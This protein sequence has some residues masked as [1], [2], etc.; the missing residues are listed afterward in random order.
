MSRFPKA[1][2]PPGILTVSC[3]LWDSNDFLYML[4]IN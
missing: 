4:K 2:S 1:V 3:K